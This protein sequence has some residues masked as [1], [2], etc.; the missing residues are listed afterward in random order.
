MH[1]CIWVDE[2]VKV[3]SLSEEAYSE[4]KKIKDNDSFSETILKI[5]KDR[6]NK[7]TDYEGFAKLAGAFKEDKEEWETI[8]KEI[9]EHRK[10]TKVSEW[11]F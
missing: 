5:I 9:Y 10:K 8:K 1:I 4:L 3:I 2:M 11:S 7:G 6:K